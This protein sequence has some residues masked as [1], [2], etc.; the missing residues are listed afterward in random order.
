[1]WQAPRQ[2]RDT[3]TLLS[4]L[5]AGQDL[6]HLLGQVDWQGV[7]PQQVCYAVLG[8]L[9]QDMHY[10]G[11]TAAAFEPPAYFRALLLGSEF[12]SGIVANLLNAFPE[13]PRRFFV[14]VPRSG[15][16][17]L[18]QTM[19]NHACTIPHD[20]IGASWCSGRGFLDLVA[21]LCRAIPAHEAI[22]VSG[23]YT[24]RS[25]VDS[26]LARFGDSVWTSLRN[27]REIVLSY[28]N[29]ILTTVEADGGMLRPDTR[30]WAGQLKLDAPPSTLAPEPLRALLSRMIRDET[31]LPRDLVCHFLGDG[32][33]ASALDLLA[34]ADVEVI[35]SVRL[36]QWREQR[37]A[38]PARPWANV[39]KRFF[40]WGGL[41]DGQKRQV[42][43]LIRQDAV[44]HRTISASFGD[45]ASVGGLRLARPPGPAASS[46][47]PPVVPRVRRAS[48]PILLDPGFTRMPAATTDGVSDR[49]G[50]V[51]WA[52]PPLNYRTIETTLRFPLIQTRIRVRYARRKFDWPWRR[53]DAVP[54][55][56]L[57]RLLGDLMR[58]G[59]ARASRL[60]R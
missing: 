12:Q 32:T 39:S 6:D 52:D 35:D 8:R 23:H 42:T 17:S 48:R 58:I 10:A 46:A 54:R 4:R 55:S 47:A 9:P 15:G 30:H 26:R 25:I 24:L 19:A 34:A 5:Q 40:H 60:D 2:L 57:H 20:A 37:W 7:T 49:G 29:Y 59:R 56:T 13:K 38:I 53:G 11:L 3:F 45:A 33:A 50:Q 28:V 1:M 41:D 14:H 18:G 27:P 31:L 22:H 16:T 51:G 44:L 36:D 43:A 21:D